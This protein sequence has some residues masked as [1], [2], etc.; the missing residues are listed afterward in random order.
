M[1]MPVTITELEIPGVLLI[2]CGCFFDNRGFFSEVYSE[3]IWSEAGFARPFV[4]DNLSLSKK[5]TEQ[6][7]GKEAPR[8]FGHWEVLPSLC[9][10]RR[11]SSRMMTPRMKV[12]GPSKSVQYVGIPTA[13][14]M[15]VIRR[16]NAMVT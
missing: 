14:S 6:A 12:G 8:T 4:Q 2:E 10:T 7:A 3:P 13:K 1:P 15:P 16:P 5:G 9:S 11:T